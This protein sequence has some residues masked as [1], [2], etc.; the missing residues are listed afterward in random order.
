MNAFNVEE[1]YQ[2]YLRRVAMTEA[3]M[4][5]VQRVETR[6]AFFG[7]WGQ[8]LL[9]LQDDIAPLP[10]DDGVRALSDMINQVAAFWENESNQFKARNQ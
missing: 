4:G 9:C 6:R 10:D 3:Q 7:A 5:T 1:Q 2:A 8:A